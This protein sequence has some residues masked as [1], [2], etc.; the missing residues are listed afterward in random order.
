MGGLGPSEGFGG[1][2]VVRLV[3]E[4]AD[5]GHGETEGERRR[6]RCRAY[7]DS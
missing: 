2:G 7:N 4:P 6:R 3:G 1:V 5:G